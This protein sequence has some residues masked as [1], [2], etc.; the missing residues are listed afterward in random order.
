M[1]EKEEAR[2]YDPYSGR[3]RRKTNVPPSTGHQAMM[4][5]KQRLSRQ[6]KQNYLENLERRYKEQDAEIKQLR[7]QITDCLS[8]ASPN[9]SNSGSVVLQVPENPTYDELHSSQSALRSVKPECQ[10]LQTKIAALRNLAFSEIAHSSIQPDNDS[11]ISTIIRT[12]SLPSTTPFND[13]T[14]EW[15]INPESKLGFKKIFHALDITANP[16]SSE[17]LHG[18]ININP[19]RNTLHALDSLKEAV[20]VDSYCDKIVFLS[21]ET[22]VKRMRQI[23][24]RIM[25]ERNHIMDLCTVIDRVKF[26]EA[27]IEHSSNLKLHF[28]ELL[29]GIE[30]LTI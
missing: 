14:Y 20:A 1:N 10:A 18:P 13:I 19:F 21:R 28:D 27:R 12:T 22:D 4:R 25:R 24:L 3:G 29:T 17:Q 26:A 11:A 9:L 7:A 6:R 30:A 23:F 15:L 16:L 2:M 8:F 5:E